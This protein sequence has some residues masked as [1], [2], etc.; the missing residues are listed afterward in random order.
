[1]VVLVLVGVASWCTACIGDVVWQ[2]TWSVMMVVAS[3]SN[4]GI[5][6]E[7]RVGGARGGLK[8]NTDIR[9]FI[10]LWTASLYVTL[11]H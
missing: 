4:C 9:T 5:A 10:S 6:R 11:I 1:M 2:M 7:S 8:L 3:T